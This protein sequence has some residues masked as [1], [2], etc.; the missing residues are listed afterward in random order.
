MDSA[1]S[2]DSLERSGR[3]GNGLIKRSGYTGD[4]VSGAELY[5]PPVVRPCQQ[6]NTSTVLI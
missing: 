2:G 4:G 6:L 1:A 5:V 3:F